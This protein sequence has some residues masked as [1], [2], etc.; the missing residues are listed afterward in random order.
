MKNN[1]SKKINVLSVKLRKL[2]LFFFV[3]IVTG[4]QSLWWTMFGSM[5]HNCLDTLCLLNHSSW[6]TVHMDWTFFF[7]FRAVIPFIQPIGISSKMT[8]CAIS[9][10]VTKYLCYGILYPYSVRHNIRTIQPIFMKCWQELK[11]IIKL[12]LDV[13]LLIVNSKHACTDS[14]RKEI[15]F[16]RQDS[17]HFIPIFSRMYITS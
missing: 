7:F 15:S 8:K 14:Q 3:W 2:W 17:C 12:V 4:L 10:F 5:S 16:K 9:T 13:F 1:N 6:P 11:Q